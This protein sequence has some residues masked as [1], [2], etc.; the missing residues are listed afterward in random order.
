M[1]QS[2]SEETGFNTG[3]RVRESSMAS[4]I[5]SWVEDGS[6]IKMP[7]GHGWR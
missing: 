2:F 1:G 5:S 6:H 7:I 4:P 3:D